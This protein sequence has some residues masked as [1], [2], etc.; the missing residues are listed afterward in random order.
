MMSYR[1]F[2]FKDYATSE[3]NAFEAFCR[4]FTEAAAYERTCIRIEPGEYLIDAAESIP[5]SS[6]MTVEAEGAVFCFPVSLGNNPVR[7]LFFGKNVRD[8]TFRGGHFK[9][10]VFDPDREDN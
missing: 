1:T 9:G 10:Y 3:S 7:H 5:L 8:F 2:Y 4:C 6:G